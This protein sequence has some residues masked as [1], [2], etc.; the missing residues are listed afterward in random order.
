M[1]SLSYEDLLRKRKMVMGELVRG[2]ETATQLKTLL[3][4]P[5]NDHRSVLAK[6]LS[7]KV[8]RSFTEILSMLNYGGGAN[9]R[10]LIAG[11][12]LG[13]SYC[14]GENNKR[15]RV[16]DRRGCYK[17]RKTSDSWTTISPAKED[18]CAWRKYGQKII[19]NAK[20]PRCYFRCTHKNQGC[21]ATKQVQKFKEQPIL[22]RTTYFGHHTCR[23]KLRTPQIIIDTDLPDSNI[24][25]FEEKS[26][27]V[28]GGSNIPFETKEDIARSDMSDTKSSPDSSLWHD[29]KSLDPLMVWSPKMKCFD[30]EGFDE[31]CDL[32]FTL[33]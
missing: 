10:S 32:D 20:Y 7:V 17:R 1:S 24:H 4:K 8:F 27:Q 2:K 33:D 15:P 14:S 9:K 18:G 22:Y 31:F 6:E 5:V 16:K 23:D 28:G 21:K 29:M 19:L 25:C 12:D 13:G 3:Q 26:S 30:M 11:G